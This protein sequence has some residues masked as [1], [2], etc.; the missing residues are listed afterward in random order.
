MTRPTLGV[1]GGMGTQA[2]AYCYELL[3]SMQSVDAEQEYLD[4]IVYS[5][6]STPDRTAFITGRSDAS[7]LA[8]LLYAAKTLE[9]A[10]ASC[11][12]MPCITSHF[13]YGELAEAVSIPILNIPKETAAFIAASGFDKIGLLATDGTICG[14]LFHGALEKSDI[15][16]I[17][18]SQDIQRGLMEVI[19]DVKR[20]RNV[21]EGAL[22]AI[23]EGLLG[24]GAQSVVL[25]CT[26]LCLL[27]KQSPNCIN[28]MEV[29]VRASLRCCDAAA[30]V[31]CRV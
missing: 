3:H 12:A 30:S 4:V 25:G 24:N 17:V 31:E 29:L 27:A 6:P 10:G 7:P 8:S 11:I 23:I 22:D 18:P 15:G 14:R 13:F 21:G 2:T 5:M 19:Y 28:T 20:G 16:I 9:A 1:L 26:E